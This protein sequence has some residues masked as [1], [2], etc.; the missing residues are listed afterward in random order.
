MEEP[1]DGKGVSR[2]RF[3][4]FLAASAAGATV[5]ASVPVAGKVAS[6]TVATTPDAELDAKPEPSPGPAEWPERR[7]AILRAHEDVVLHTREE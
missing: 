2:R 5:A 3:L 6:A 7:R 1:G 4:S